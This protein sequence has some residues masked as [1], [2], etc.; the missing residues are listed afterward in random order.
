MYNIGREAACSF[1]NSNGNRCSAVFLMSY[2]LPVSPIAMKMHDFQSSPRIQLRELNES[3]CGWFRYLL[4]DAQWNRSSVKLIVVRWQMCSAR[5]AALGWF[6]PPAIVHRR[7]RVLFSRATQIIH[8]AD[9]LTDDMW[10]VFDGL[11]VQNVSYVRKQNMT[12][13]YTTDQTHLMHSGCCTFCIYSRPTSSSKPLS[14]MP[15]RTS[16]LRPNV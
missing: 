1:I 15:S 10:W 6:T 7:T 12:K 13:E 3:T 16:L 4:Y 8:G 11:L 2:V 5:T 9:H 14:V